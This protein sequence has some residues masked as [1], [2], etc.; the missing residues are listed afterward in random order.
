MSGSPTAELGTTSCSPWSSRLAILRAVRR[1]KPRRGS[2][3]HRRGQS[4]C[5]GLL[6]RRGGRAELGSAL[7]R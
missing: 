4:N 7:A 3:V 2:G 1:R 5:E 6:G